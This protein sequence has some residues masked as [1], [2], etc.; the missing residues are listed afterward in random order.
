MAQ[1]FTPFAEFIFDLVKVNEHF[2]ESVLTSAKEKNDRTPQGSQK[3]YA[4]YCFL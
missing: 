2:A 1:Q 4:K 3:P